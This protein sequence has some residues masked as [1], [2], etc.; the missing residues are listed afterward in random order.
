MPHN[1]TDALAERDAGLVP[2]FI[3]A[4]EPIEDFAARTADEEAAAAAAL[5]QADAP[6][7]TTGLYPLDPGYV[8]T[9]AEPSPDVVDDGTA[10]TTTNGESLPAPPPPPEL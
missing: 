8:P 9:P 4:G 7:P 3:G 1:W 2:G 5:E 6:A 10:E